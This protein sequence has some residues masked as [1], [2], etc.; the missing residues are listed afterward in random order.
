MWATAMPAFLVSSSLAILKFLDPLM[1]ES[2]Q[3]TFKKYCIMS[4]RYCNMVTK[5]GKLIAK[6][7]VSKSVSYFLKITI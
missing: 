3:S 1:H 7:F 6:S 4:F 5:K 2:I